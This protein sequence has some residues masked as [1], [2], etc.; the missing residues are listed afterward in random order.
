MSDY[1]SHIQNRLR[2]NIQTLLCGIAPLSDHDLT[3]CENLEYRSTSQAFLH[4]Q[5]YTEQANEDGLHYPLMP[6]ILLGGN[7]TN[8][9]EQKAV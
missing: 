5:G 7:D 1:R 4:L 2:T 6:P 3:R 8:P 9:E